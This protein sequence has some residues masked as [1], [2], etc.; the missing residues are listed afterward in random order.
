MFGWV[1]EEFGLEFL[2]MRWR[3]ERESLE[4]EIFIVNSSDDSALNLILN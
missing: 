4:R 3:N 2:M 1:I